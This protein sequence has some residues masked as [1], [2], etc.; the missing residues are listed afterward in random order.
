MAFFNLRTYSVKDHLPSQVLNYQSI[1]FYVQWPKYHLWSLIPLQL[2]WTALKNVGKVAS[3]LP[4][5]NA[6]IL[7]SY[8]IYCKSQNG[9]KFQ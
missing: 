5:C 8:P 7:L 1:S 9:W 6:S 3:C 4:I 2:I